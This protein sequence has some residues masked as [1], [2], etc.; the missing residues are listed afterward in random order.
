MINLKKI[1]A[2]IAISAL[3]L[4]GI[5][6]YSGELNTTNLISYAYSDMAISESG[7]NLI[8]SFEGCRLTAYKLS[9]EKYYTI[10]YGHY[11]SDVYSGMTITQAQADTYL[12]QD[13]KKA[14]KQVN[15]FLSKNNISV[16]QNQFDALVS[17]TFNLGDVWTSTAT[18]Q[19]KTYLIN[20]VSNYNSSQITTAFTNWNKDGNMQPL[21]GLTKRRKAEAELFLTGASVVCDCSASYAGTY[22]TYDV[23]TSLNIRSESSHSTNGSVV[24]SI[25]SGAKFNVTKANGS[26]AHVNYNGTTGIVSMSYIRRVDPPW[27]SELTPVD[28]GDELYGYIINSKEWKHLTND[29]ENVSFR[30]QTGAKNQLWKFTK[31]SDGSYKIT[32]L[33]DGKVLDV[34]GESSEND[35]NVGVYT[36]KNNN[37]QKWYIYG[38]SGQNFLKAACTDCVLDLDGGKF[39]EGVNAQ[40]WKYDSSDDAEKLH[41]WELKKS[42]ELSVDIGNSAGKTTFTWNSLE[43]ADHYDVKIWNGTY[44]DGDYAYSDWHNKGT[45]S[46]FTLPAGHYE[47]YVDTVTPDGSVY[48]SNVVKFDVKAATFNVTFN[49][50]GGS[51]STT[52]K[53]VTHNS[54]YGSLP[55]PTRTG[56]TFNGWFTATS[57]GTKITDTTKVTI[58]ANQTLY[59]QWK[60]NGYTIAY[61]SNGGSGSVGNS[62]MTYDKA[63]NLNANS[64]TR[65][66][67]TF[68][69]WNTK[70][71]GSGTAYTD[72]ASVKNLASSGTVTLYA[73][74]KA[75]SVSVKFFRNHDGNDTSSVTETFT[76]GVAN[77]KFGYK[78]DGTGR[79]SP[80]NSA[81]VGFGAWSKTGY[82]LLGWST[83]RNAKS[84]E[85]YTYSD[86][87][88]F[89]DFVNLKSP[90]VNLYA[91]WKAKQYTVTFDANG[92]SVSPTSQTVTY[93]S[94][95]GSLP[96]PTRT[97]YIFNGWFTEKNGG[98]KITADTKVT[99]TANQTLYAQWS[100]TDEVGKSMT[101]KEAAGQTIPD[102]DYW[103]YSGLD[104]NYYLDIPGNEI[105]SN[106]ANVEMWMSESGMPTK[107][108]VWT[109][110]Y[111]NNGF[112]KITQYGTS[113]CLDVVNTSKLNNTNV[114]IYTEHTTEAQQWSISKTE[115][116]Y[117]IQSRCNGFYLDVE[118]AKVEKGTN[119]RVSKKNDDKRQSFCFIPY[120]PDERPL[121]DGVYGIQSA[122]NS[123]YYV[124]AA[125]NTKDFANGTN[126]CIGDKMYD[127]FRVEYAGEGY[128]KIF[129][130]TTGLAVEVSNPYDYHYYFSDNLRNIHLYESN[131][132]R[133][134]LWK[135]RKTSDGHYFIISKLSG[136]YF[137]LL[138]GECVKGQNISQV[139][140]VG[141]NAQKWNFV[142]TIIKGDANDDKT[143]DVADAVMLQKWLLGSGTLTN[144]KN[145][146]L[147]EDGKIDVFDMIE[148]RKLITKK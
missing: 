103:I 81:N 79:Y 3:M 111:L 55:T 116:G 17:F 113:I 100:A 101:E 80:M 126:I 114:Q 23:Q 96:T 10:G 59:S 112:Y 120:S 50:N 99:I 42:A 134:Q 37:A 5:A 14:E 110:K 109:V 104:R 63:S 28:I 145:V 44:W 11:G 25:P 1:V 130:A 18:F 136:C 30:T 119:V 117:R 8:K 74:W 137:D 128:Y 4:G 132:S 65:T 84:I 135:I 39:Y 94:N 58:T 82:E 54:T 141:G 43:I 35:A 51:V 98:T 133:G 78:T 61:N 64:F 20:G 122:K 73:Q 29:G 21:E 140:Y 15:N 105:V 19:L 57:G 68:N 75:K 72:K 47:A 115:T 107:Y 26:I 45:S 121:A 33:A 41:L 85:H 40:M 13:V 127:T 142:S 9:G 66:G 124:D 48:M 60:I 52:S 7:L 22:T 31:N 71:D 118:G 97:G 123:E 144:W 77:Q 53:T 76:Y 131:S 147:C 38:S 6:G 102:G 92:G 34:T 138:N 86:V 125:G 143:V 148:M 46:S 56:Y 91:V 2:S 12:R 27:H 83:D 90:S 49:A 24:G 95:Y 70:A 36:D 93:N 108:D 139:Y 87:S 129:E 16:T 88:Q 67:Y 106:N 89:S 32:S 69:G 62:S 146:D